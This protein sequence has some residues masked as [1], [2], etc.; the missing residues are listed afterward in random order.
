MTLERIVLWV[1]MLALIIWLATVAL[2]AFFGLMAWMASAPLTAA[3]RW[4]RRSLIPG[5]VWLIAFLLG[6]FVL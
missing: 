3:R 5:I 4:L 6:R 2:A 1:E